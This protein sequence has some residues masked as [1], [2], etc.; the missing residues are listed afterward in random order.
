MV[1]QWTPQEV[2]EWLDLIKVR[3]VQNQGSQNQN[4]IFR[5]ESREKKIGVNLMLTSCTE[6]SSPVTSAHFTQS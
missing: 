3:V 2:Q 4:L 1:S 5:G 6:E